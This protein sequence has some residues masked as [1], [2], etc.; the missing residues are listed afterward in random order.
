MILPREQKL[1]SRGD[2][3]NQK[4]FPLEFAKG[5]ILLINVLTQP[6]NGEISTKIRLRTDDFIRNTNLASQIVLSHLGTLTVKSYRV[7]SVAARAWMPV[8]RNLK[9][10]T[11]EVGIA[12]ENPFWRKADFEELRQ[13]LVDGHEGAARGGVESELNRE[14][15]RRATHGT[16]ENGTEAIVLRL[17]RHELGEKWEFPGGDGN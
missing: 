5:N 2:V 8:D 9:D 17:R 7:F 11:D 13:D 15:P 6:E 1:P 10:A 3:D 16:A 12:T 4:N 14:Q